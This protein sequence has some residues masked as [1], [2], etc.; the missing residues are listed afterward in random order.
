MQPS[1][2]TGAPA[3]PRVQRSS[4]VDLITAA[5]R[6]A[7]YTGVMLPGSA[8][9]EIE[10]ARQ[11]GVSRGP[12]REA[13]QR[14][15]QEGLLDAVPG[16][17]LVVAA[18]GPEDVPGLYEARLAI[19]SAAIRA[20]AALD[21]DVRRTRLAPAQAVL[22]RLGELAGD[23]RA[24]ATALEIGDADLDFHF[25]SVRAAG[26]E[27]LTR[28]MSTLVIETRLASLGASGGYEVRTDIHEPHRR[29]LDLLLA[30]DGEAAVALLRGHFHEAVA[31][32]TGRGPAEARTARLDVAA[33][34]PRLGPIGA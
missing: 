12:F 34:H 14:L 2:S 29:R 26:N 17:G 7:V 22:R 1:P 21:P 18:V 20:L 24:E 19:E 30:G 6:D 11:L 13:A 3:M 31:R 32:L 28:M 23:G 25:E 33:V 4:T 9:R 5:L 10:T 8:L 16:Q 27:R 15:V